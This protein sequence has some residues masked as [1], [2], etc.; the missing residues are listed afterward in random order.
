MVK[1]AL[2][3]AVT[4]PVRCLQR[5]IP[6]SFLV[7]ASSSFEGVTL[8]TLP[9]MLVEVDGVTAADGTLYAERVAGLTNSTGA[10]LGRH[11]V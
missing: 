6:L 8:T 11:A 10:V 5:G 1:E 7:D 9:N 4:T 3:A 2:S